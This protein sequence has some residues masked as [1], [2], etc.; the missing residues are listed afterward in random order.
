MQRKKDGNKGGEIVQADAKLCTD[1]GFDVCKFCVKTQCMS[2]I[3][4]IKLRALNIIIF[5]YYH[6]YQ[7]AH[8]AYNNSESF[9]G[10]HRLVASF[11]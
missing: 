9:T 2:L 5:L 3:M 7:K 6:F 4:A 8:E 1:N 11:S 10:L